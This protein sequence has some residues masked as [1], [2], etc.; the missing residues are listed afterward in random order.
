MAQSQKSSSE[1]ATGSGTGA[2]KLKDSTSREM[3][4]QSGKGNGAATGMSAQD[5]TGGATEQAGRL[6]DA[7]REQATEQIA[8]QKDRAASSLGI[9]AQA[10]HQAGQQVREQ[11]DTKL[12]TYV[13]SA[14][15]QVER[16]AGALEERD[17][18][19]LINEAGRFARREPALFLAS[20]FALGFVGT[21]F[22]RSGAQSQG[23]SSWSGS[24]WDRPMSGQRNDRYGGTYA[25]GY[26]GSVEDR[27]MESEGWSGSGSLPGAS[28]SGQNKTGDVVLGS[29]WPTTRGFDTGPEAR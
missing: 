17:I 10:L 3:N 19:Q 2:G 1:R 23:Q 11:D 21:R 22:L 24:S 9:L 6:V 18:L 28:L 20:A 25:Y 15:D 14:A 26:V 27:G 7:A 4:R 5:E 29:E 12:A 8:T 16:L 13:D